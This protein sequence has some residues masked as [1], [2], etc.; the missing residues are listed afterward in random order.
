[1][2]M[3]P[4]INVIVVGVLKKIILIFYQIKVFVLTQSIVAV[5]PFTI[6][7]IGVTWMFR[8]PR[9]AISYIVIRII[10]ICTALFTGTSN[11]TVPHY[12]SNGGNNSNVCYFLL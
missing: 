1:M 10:V 8:I 7:A 12:Q 3:C 4:L 2:L 11:A 6:L 5:S 9:N